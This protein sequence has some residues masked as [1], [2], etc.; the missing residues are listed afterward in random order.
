MDQKLDQII[1]KLPEYFLPDQAV[2]LTMTAQL[3]LQDDTLDYWSLKIENQHCEVRHEKAIL[4][5]YELT[6]SSSDLIDI[7]TGKL[8]ATRAYMHGKLYLRGNILQA[9]KL[10]ELFDIPDEIRGKIQF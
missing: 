7:L 1:L 4:P 9:L 2:G 6:V 3:N 8:D 5:Q 10:I